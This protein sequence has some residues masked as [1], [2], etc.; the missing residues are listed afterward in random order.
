MGRHSVSRHV[1]QLLFGPDS[2]RR[3]GAVQAQELRVCGAALCVWC[4]QVIGG[5]SIGHTDP[6]RVMAAVEEQLGACLCPADGL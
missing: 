2:Q 6:Y 1:P 4:T 3:V 5:A